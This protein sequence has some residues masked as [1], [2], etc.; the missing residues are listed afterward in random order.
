MG[1]GEARP[2]VARATPLGGGS[3]DSAGLLPA[4]AARSA[5]LATPSILTRDVLHKHHA[6][7]CAG[8]LLPV[9]LHAAAWCSRP[10]H[11]HTVR[12]PSWQVVV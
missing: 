6:A 5:E 7:P 11:W 3:R 4:A 2:A 1:W 12:R 8:L 10:L 9:P